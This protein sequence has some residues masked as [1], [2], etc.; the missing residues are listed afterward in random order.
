MTSHALIS[1]EIK[2]TSIT[3]L[4]LHAHPHLHRQVSHLKS[5][6]PRLRDWNC[7]IYQHSVVIFRL[8]IKRT[9]ITRLK[10]ES[11]Y[12]HLNLRE[13]LEIKRTSITRLKPISNHPLS[14]NNQ[15]LE[16]KR[17]SITRLKRVE[18]VGLGHYVVLLKSKEPRLRDWN[19]AMMMQITIVVISWNQKNLD[20]EIETI[21]ITCQHWTDF[22]FSWNQKNLDYEIETSKTLTFH[23][24]HVPLKSK[25]PRLRDWNVVKWEQQYE[26]W[27]TWNQKNLDYEIETVTTTTQIWFVISLEIKRTSI[28]RLKQIRH[29]PKTCVRWTWNQKNLDYEIETRKIRITSRSVKDNLKSKEPRLRDWNCAIGSW[30]NIWFYLSWNQKNLD[31]EIE[32]EVMPLVTNAVISLEI[33]RTSITRLKQILW[34]KPTTPVAQLEIKR[35]SI[36]R[37]KLLVVR[38]VSHPLLAALKSKEPRLRDWNK[39]AC[40]VNAHVVSLEIKRTSITRL[41]PEHATRT[42]PGLDFLK[43][44]EPRL[45]DWN[46]WLKTEQRKLRA[47]L[48]IKRTSITRLKL[49]D[50]P[51]TAVHLHCLE[52]KRTSI[53]R[54]KRG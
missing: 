3:R 45:R 27:R 29:R 24:W 43:S 44:K 35:T 19:I 48:E 10:R 50:S 34:R 5:K 36:T 9:S 52:I 42:E 53:T 37:L 4:K 22:A 6:E 28:T 20:Y 13:K 16:I 51:H 12:G 33:K 46:I 15:T 25:E 54:L 30:S 41:K 38:A 47:S 8:E 1:L 11:C 21:W 31:Y 7:N 26:S 32:T 14:G 40:G 23:N 2:R 49:T 39:F 18:W 17:T